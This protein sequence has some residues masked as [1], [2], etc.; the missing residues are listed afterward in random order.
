MAGRREREGEMRGIK[1]IKGNQGKLRNLYHIQTLDA[2]HVILRKN[3]LKLSYSKFHNDTEI[4]FQEIY[5]GTNVA[6]VWQGPQTYT[7]VDP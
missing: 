6:T 2:Y 7:N 4:P 1:G 3:I 5:G